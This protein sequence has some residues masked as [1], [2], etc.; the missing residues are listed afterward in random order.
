MEAK[1][2]REAEV[3]QL[4][5][6]ALAEAA[7]PRYV[8]KLSLFVISSQSQP[9]IRGNRECCPYDQQRTERKG[10]PA[11]C[12]TDSMAVASGGVGGRHGCVWHYPDPLFSSTGSGYRSYQRS[13]PQTQAPPW[14]SSMMLHSTGLNVLVCKQDPELPHRVVETV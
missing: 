5:R 9:R 7:G 6:I 3:Q 10:R 13:V 2:T 8:P 4:P 14:T 12:L 11:C 1:P